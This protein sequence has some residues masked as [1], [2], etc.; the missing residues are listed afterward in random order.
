MRRDFPRRQ[1]SLRTDQ[2]TLIDECEGEA[3]QQRP[4]HLNGE[5]LVVVGGVR[6]FLLEGWVLHTSFA[7]CNLA[8][9]RRWWC[10]SGS[11]GIG[12]AMVRLPPPA[13]YQSMLYA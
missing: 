7:P 12:T 5:G 13:W 11:R 1:V 3:Q 4:A 6:V 2:I 9:R 8:L 10:L